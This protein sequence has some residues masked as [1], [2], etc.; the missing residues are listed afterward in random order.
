VPNTRPYGISPHDQEP[1]KRGSG[2]FL[3]KVGFKTLLFGFLWFISLILMD[4]GPK[5][6]D[7]EPNLRTDFERKLG[8]DP[9]LKFYIN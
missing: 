2:A 1:K 7:L 3:P 6:E 8:C 9:Q 4:L 5:S